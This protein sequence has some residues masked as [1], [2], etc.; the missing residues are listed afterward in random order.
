MHT[1]YIH[2]PALKNDKMLNKKVFKRKK[3]KEYTKLEV[4]NLVFTPVLAY[5]PGCG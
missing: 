2:Q 3:A 1:V 5:P 4:Y